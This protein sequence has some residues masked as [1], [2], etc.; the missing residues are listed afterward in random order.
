MIEHIVLF[1]WKPNTTEAQIAQ[2][3]EGLRSLKMQIS[4]IVD[5]QVGADFSGRSQGYSHALVMRLTDRAALEA[6]FPHP[7]HRRIV[8]EYINPIREDTLAFDLECE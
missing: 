5:L 8:E 4:G 7:A 1:R 2:V 3:V 6:Y